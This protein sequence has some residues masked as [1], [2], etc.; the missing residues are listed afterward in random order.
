LPDVALSDLEAAALSAPAATAGKGLAKHT[1]IP[2]ANIKAARPLALIVIR[3]SPHL[4]A[5]TGE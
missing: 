2:V 1:K 4:P 3:Q 5:H